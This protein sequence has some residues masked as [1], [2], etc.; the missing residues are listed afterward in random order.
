MGAEGGG[1][2]VAEGST[3]S[4]CATDR[5]HRLLR[6][7]PGPASVEPDLSGENTGPSRDEKKDIFFQKTSANALEWS[8]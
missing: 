6:K 3:I 8:L 1:I 7:G 2:R 5:H 4:E